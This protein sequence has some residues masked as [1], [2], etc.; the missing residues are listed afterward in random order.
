ME[1]RRSGNDAGKNAFDGVDLQL[2]V[3]VGERAVGKYQT[4]IKTD[5]RPA[6][7]KNKTHKSADAFVFLDP[8]AIVNPNQGEVLHVVENLKQRDANEQ[9]GDSVI[10]IPPEGDARDQ[11]RE[12]HRISSLRLPPTPS[13]IDQEQDRNCNGEKKQTT[14]CDLK[15][16]RLNE[17]PATGVKHA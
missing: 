9:I 10:A 11:E 5:E 15:H 4:E 6:A 16:P 2:R 17:G 7:S 3:K 12:F 8:V 1:Q 14:L 13:E